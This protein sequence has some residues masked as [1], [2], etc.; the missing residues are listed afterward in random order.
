[1][2]TSKHT[3]VHFFAAAEYPRSHSSSI[4]LAALAAILAIFSLSG[5]GGLASTEK[6]TSRITLTV[7]SSSINF[8]NISVGSSATQSLIIT[9]IG[10]PAVNVSQATI[11]GAGFALVG[12]NLTYSIP[13]GQSSTIQIQ[14]APLS[15]G[16][17]TGSLSILSNASN[18]LLAIALAGTGAQ[19]SSQNIKLTNSGNADLALSLATV[20]GNGFG[21][22]GLSVPTTISPGQ[23]LSFNGHFAPTAAGGATGSITFAD[24]AAGSPQ[25][26]TLSGSGVTASATLSA[27][28]GSIA[29]GNIVVGNTS[30]QTI[31]LANSGSTN[32][33]ISQISLSGTGFNASGLATPMTLAAGQ[34]ATFTAQFAPAAAGNTSGS[35]TLTSD[36]SNPTLTIALSG[37]GTQGQLAA[38][39][40]S[41]SFGNV[42]VG[43]SG[44]Q[45][46]TLTN[47]GTA[48]VTLSA[49]SA[50]GTGFSI[51]GLS[52]PLTLAA[53][54]NTTFTAQFAPS[55][56]GSA[57]GTASITSNAPGSPLTIALS[58]TGV[59]ATFLLGANPASLSFGNVNVGGNG[60]SSVT[61]TN[62][63]NSNVNISSVT[64]S[65]AG[66]SASGVSA[67]TNLTPNQSL[68]LNVAFAPTT[69]GSVTGSV[70]VA[71]NATNSPAVISLSG[72]GVQPQI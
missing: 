58:G 33:T 1:M 21:I 55:A 14:F 71:S 54:Q 66:F 41:V 65:G 35:I 45:T 44:S 60:S 17:V 57:S 23:S 61:L 16:D 37:T 30:T 26:L 63:G 27:N 25:T 53:G 7:N 10:I 31:T 32:V 51:S 42:L 24:N 38:N 2:G 46:V 50:S 64:V 69:A 8:G 70:S 9:N 36:A 56:T 6:K 18:P 29:F 67:G 68:T 4:S 3:Q 49:A 39:P 15:T 13:G 19:N 62:T 5:C 72:A 28:P 43:S 12:A 34:S 59:A 52:L 48:S 40:A 11:S 47:S 22:S 20:S